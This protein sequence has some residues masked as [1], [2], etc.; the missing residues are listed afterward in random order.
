MRSDNP[1]KDTL[2]LA[3]VS[4]GRLELSFF[5]QAVVSIVSVRMEGCK[6]K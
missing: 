2:L 5:L 4:Q 1:G 6:D 3:Q